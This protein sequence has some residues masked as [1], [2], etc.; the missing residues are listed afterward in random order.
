M[1]EIVVIVLCCLAGLALI[2]I[3]AVATVLMRIAA[4]P[5]RSTMEASVNYVRDAGVYGGFDEIEKEAVSISSF[6]GYLLNGFFIPA[7]EQSDR[8]VIISHGITDTLYGSVKYANIYHRLGFHVLI[9][10]LRNHGSNKETYT[11]MGIRESK[12]LSQIILYMR[13]RF[14]E[15][16]RLGIH[17]ESLGSATSIMCLKE[18][19]SLAFC[20]ADCGF[21]KLVSLM[22]YLVK[23]EYHVPS[24]L[25]PIGNFLAMLLYHYS[26][27]TIC[28]IDS[29]WENQV[30]IMFIHGN[31]DTFIP[32]FMSQEMYDANRGYKEI[33][34]FPDAKHA[35]SL[36][37]APEK[38]EE[39]L[40]AFLKKVLG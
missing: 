20:V 17:G 29:L 33:H 7:K 11:T 8:Y 18:N 1:N 28:P 22:K 12:D 24:W 19:Q 39:V 4:K 23:A 32:P 30:P 5:K 9:Y 40:K 27:Y 35:G 38:Y 25:I 34:F 37:S 3:L 2:G 14:G 31:A 6:D 26:F 36:A 10:H 13:K 21:S 16:I 15:N